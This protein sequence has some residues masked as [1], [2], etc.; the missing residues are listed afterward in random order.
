M[1]PLSPLGAVL[2]TG[3]AH[4]ILVSIFPNEYVFLSRYALRAAWD[5]VRPIFVVSTECTFVGSLYKSWK[6][7]G[8]KQ[9]FHSLLVM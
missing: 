9:L 7:D 1:K 2:M 5:T 6:L 4:A 3:L 8:N